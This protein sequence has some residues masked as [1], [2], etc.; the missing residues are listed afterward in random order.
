MKEEMKDLSFLI[1]SLFNMF[2]ENTVIVSLYS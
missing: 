2:T 1:F